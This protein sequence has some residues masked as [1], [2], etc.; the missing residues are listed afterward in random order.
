MARKKREAA[1]TALVESRQLPT[2][3]GSLTH[4]PTRLVPRYKSSVPDIDAIWNRWKKLGLA[5]KR[6]ILTELTRDMDPALLPV[7]EVY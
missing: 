5:G 7:S 6:F 3:A 2:H 4:T 1:Q